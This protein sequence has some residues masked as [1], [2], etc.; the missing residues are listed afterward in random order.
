MQLI[1]RWRGR[2]GAPRGG[3]EMPARAIARALERADV[4]LGGQSLPDARRRPPGATAADGRG[5]GSTQG[6]RASPTTSRARATVSRV[7]HQLK[8][9][10]RRRRTAAAWRGPE[11]LDRADGR[12]YIQLSAISGGL[13]SRPV[14]ARLSTA[15]AAGC[16]SLKEIPMIS[17]DNKA[18]SHRRQRP[19]SQRHQQPQEVQV[20]IMTARINELTPLQDPRQGPPRPSRSAQAGQPSPQAARLPEVQGRRPLRRPDPE[21]GPA[22]VILPQPC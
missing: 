13:S 16:K 10:D 14:A 8:A 20:A 11:Q 22:Q 7:V 17:R 3:Q 4:T 9:E 18:Q 12:G 5:H 19:R 21:A 1:G 2:S 6:R 15:A